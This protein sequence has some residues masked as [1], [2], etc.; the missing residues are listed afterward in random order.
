[1]IDLINGHL[2][3]GYMWDK[4][5]AWR[6]YVWV[7]GALAQSWNFAGQHTMNQVFLKANLEQMNAWTWVASGG[8]WL[9]ATNDRRTRGGPAMQDPRS[10]WGDLYWDTNS[11]SKLFLSLDVN[12]SADEVHSLDVPISPSVTWKPSSRISISGGPTF[13]FNRQDA[14]Y[15]THVADPLAT[16]T[17]GGRYVF[18]HLD[19]TTMGASLR[20]DCS[21]TSNLSL[22]VY[23]QPLVS[24]GRYSDYRELARPGTYDFLRYGRDGGSTISTGGDVVADPDGA[25]PAPAFDLG[26][27]DFT[28]RT[29]RGDAVLRWE[30]VPGSTFYVVW[31]QDRTDV[32]GDGTF[33]LRPSISALARTPANNRLRV[34]LAHHFQI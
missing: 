22:Q 6:K 27:P 23:V 5:T 2:G 1:M 11:A 20:V 10:W 26:H 30:Y 13:D 25:G 18:A 9:R 29:V 7:I 31:T 17:G 14:Q 15:V 12:P 4:P 8:Y 33:S 16:A 21:L 34:K 19:Q 24:S 28:F 3:L 32:I